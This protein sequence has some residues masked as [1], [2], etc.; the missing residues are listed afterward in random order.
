MSYR[1]KS[2]VLSYSDNKALVKNR[3]KMCR[4][5]KRM[6]N[7][8]K[9][10]SI[11]NCSFLTE[12]RTNDLVNCTTLFTPPSTSTLDKSQ[13]R[14]V[15]DSENIADNMSASD[16][17]AL[18]S[19][20]NTSIVSNSTQGS[21]NFFTTDNMSALD[22]TPAETSA[23]IQPQNYLSKCLATWAI[24]ENIKLNSLNKL[25]T[26]LKGNFDVSEFKKL[27]KD[28]R[29]LLNTPNFINIK[30]FTGGSYYY[31]G[32]AET[33]NALCIGKKVVL[34]SSDK[35]SIAVNIDGVPLYKSTGDSFWPIL[36][37]V[38][39][40]K[41]LENIVFCVA[42]YHGIKNQNLISSFQTL[43]MNVFS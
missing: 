5:R 16:I 31:F 33:L 12:L 40:V 7:K 27:P 1:N 38:K 18:I 28:S 3:V 8:Y 11:S 29:T 39:S 4:E 25:L 17:T 15:S 26:I 34:T 13:E 32:I 43:L 22:T 21:Q 14:L 19:N 36:C 20:N 30:K 37:L 41:A 9:V 2:R 6:K 23:L 24:E 35:I 10:S 42:M